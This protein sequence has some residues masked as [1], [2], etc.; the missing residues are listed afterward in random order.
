MEVNV[1][2]KKILYL[3][4]G[5]ISLGVGT[6]AAVIP[7]LPS[8]PFLLLAF[9]CFGK[10]SEKMKEWF[11]STKL[12]KN[13]LESFLK[14]EGMSKRA[15]IKTMISVSIVMLFGFF[16]MGEFTF[17]RILLGIIW[18]FHIWYFSIRVKT[19]EPISN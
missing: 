1:N 11:L 12:Y 8:F 19:I 3:I 16:M 13:N 18:I 7:L 10:S 15:K 6:I 9:I 5:F 14:G 4:L 17:G 2:L